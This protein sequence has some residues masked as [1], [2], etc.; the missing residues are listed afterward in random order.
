MCPYF[1]ACL[2]A[3][4][5]YGI[6]PV[7]TNTLLQWQADQAATPD[8][9]LPPAYVGLPR[10]VN[11]LTNITCDAKLRDQGHTGSCWMWGCQGVMTLDY[12]R[13]FPAEAL[14]M[15]NGFSTQFISSYLWTVDT[16]LNEGGTPQLF[17]KLFDSFG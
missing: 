16:G 1:S 6:L 7:T 2:S 5:D 17:K 3:V 4:A 9:E 15:T 10:E 12:A 8:Y 13:Q 11:L 14:A